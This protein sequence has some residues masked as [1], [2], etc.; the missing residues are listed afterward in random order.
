M[1]REKVVVWRRRVIDPP[2][3]P[4]GWPGTTP[5]TSGSARGV[6]VRLGLVP[7]AQPRLETAPERASGV[8][9]HS[10]AASR[11]IAVARP[12]IGTDT[13]RAMSQEN[14]ELVRSIYAAWEG[15]D[16]SSAEWAHPEIE[17]VG[18]DGPEPDSST[19]LAEM[20]RNFRNG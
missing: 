11:G 2:L 13:G 20:A 8:V 1:S 10:R 3:A 6:E 17:Y 18:A 12:F 15:G 16:F 19:G 4:W 9:C 14:V 5:G 7:P